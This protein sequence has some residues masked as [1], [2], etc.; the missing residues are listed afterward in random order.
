MQKHHFLS[1]S[2]LK[3]LPSRKEE[4]AAP[5]PLAFPRIICM[6]P[7][8]ASTVQLHIWCSAKKYWQ[9]C[10]KNFIFSRAE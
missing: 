8:T 3:Q 6:Q 2:C 7:C 4:Q 10:V 1:L 9:Q 5:H